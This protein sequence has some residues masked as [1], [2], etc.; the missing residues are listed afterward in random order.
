MELDTA[1][2]DLT[3]VDLRTRGGLG[4]MVHDPGA[5][6]LRSEGHS[7]EGRRSTAETRV[8]LLLFAWAGCVHQRLRD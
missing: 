8:L 7:R 2:A 5:E 1:L 3:A 6:E 4:S